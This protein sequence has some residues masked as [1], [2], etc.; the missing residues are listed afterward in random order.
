MKGQSDRIKT[1]K[2]IFRLLGKKKVLLYRLLFF[3]SLDLLLGIVQPF[4]YYIFINNV[5]VKGKTSHLPI[6]IAGYLSIF[7]LQTLLVKFTRISYNTLFIKLKIELRVNILKRYINMKAGSY[8]KYST[9]DLENRID[10]DV[11]LFETFLQKHVMDYFFPV[12]KILVISV[13]L[14]AMNQTLTIIGFIVIPFS[15]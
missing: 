5:I 13:I 12:S 2:K 3:K 15:F 4:F 11:E 8:T 9:G 6:V 10:H 14:F 1:L 7:L